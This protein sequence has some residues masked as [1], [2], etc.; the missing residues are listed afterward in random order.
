MSNIL[1]TR[2]KFQN[3]IGEIIEATLGIDSLKSIFEAA[4]QGD[5]EA[6]QRIENAGG[7][8]FAPSGMLSLRLGIVDKETKE[9]LLIAQAAERTLQSIEEVENLYAVHIPAMQQLVEQGSVD[10]EYDRQSL[11]DNYY[12]QNIPDADMAN[13]SFKFIGSQ[14]DAEKLVTAQAM[15]AL[16]VQYEHHE[17][18]ALKHQL[19]DPDGSK[20]PVS[21]GKNYLEGF[22]ACTARSYQNAADALKGKGHH[23]LAKDMDE[24]VSSITYDTEASA[25]YSPAH[26]GIRLAM[27]Q[28]TQSMFGPSDKTDLEQRKETLLLRSSQAERCRFE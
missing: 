18:N 14:G 24:V 7:T 26:F 12:S 2:S 23:A 1:E 17:K 9:A 5:T 15:H 3:R 6:Q 19:I 10:T 4:E 25:T 8:G 27:L 16:M 20:Q 28:N 22:K 13:P 21:F 11:I